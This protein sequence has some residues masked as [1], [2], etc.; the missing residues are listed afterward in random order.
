M[1][2]LSEI[3]EALFSSISQ[4]DE[5]AVK[6]ALAAGANPMVLHPT[7]R[8]SPLGYA[9]LCD[10]PMIIVNLLLEHGV[11]VMGNPANDYLLQN[12]PRT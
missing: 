8:Y 9:V 6:A 1:N 3:D 11:C 10:V 2:T 12:A 7:S 5:A 4:E